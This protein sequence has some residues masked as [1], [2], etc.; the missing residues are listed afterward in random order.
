MVY[1][2]V[3]WCGRLVHGLVCYD[4][5]PRPRDQYEIPKSQ[6]ALHRKLGAGNFGE[7]YQGTW[8]GK[9]G[10]KKNKKQSNTKIKNLK[11]DEQMC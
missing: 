9:V 11:Y 6:I 2:G 8:Q 7:V 3:V 4:K 5:T 10:D 1:F